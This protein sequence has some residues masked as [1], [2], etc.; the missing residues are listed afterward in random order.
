MTGPNNDAT[1][2]AQVG[3]P[4]S[5]ALV[6]VNPR[7]RNGGASLDGALAVLAAGGLEVVCHVPGESENPSDVIR[8]HAADG[9]DRVI[10]GGGDGTLSAA[11]PA[12][13]ET[14]LPL[15]ILPLGTANDLARSLGI[16]A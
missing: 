16:P 11:A 10:V 15:G 13:V 12:I 9:C 7:A 3:A 5:R 2:A 1:A 6:V 4:R 14:G 8:A